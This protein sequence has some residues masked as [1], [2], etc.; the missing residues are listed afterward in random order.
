MFTFLFLAVD[1]PQRSKISCETAASSEESRY[2]FISFWAIY[3]I[4]N[5]PFCS[6][7]LQIPDADFDKK[8][9][10]DPQLKD[11]SRA[12]ILEC[13]DTECAQLECVQE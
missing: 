1:R 6:H 9:K 4:T 12:T 10:T 5:V 3:C 13:D 8:L 7:N 11:A 2:I